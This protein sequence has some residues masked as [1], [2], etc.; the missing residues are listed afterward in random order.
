MG[1]LIPREEG[2]RSRPVGAGIS[3]QRVKRDHED[4]SLRNQ[5]WNHL[6]IEELHHVLDGRERG[7]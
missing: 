6:A 3:L 5:V 1:Q 4:I 7:S 2:P